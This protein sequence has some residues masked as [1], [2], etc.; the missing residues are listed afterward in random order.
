MYT[1]YHLRSANEITTD[2]IDSIKASFKSKPI[3]II[4]IV[5]ENENTFELNAETKSDLDNRL[6]KD[7]KSYLSGEEYINDS[8]WVVKSTFRLAEK[9][10]NEY[11]KKWKTETGG[12]SVTVHKV[13]NINYLQIIGMGKNA[14]PFILKDLQKGPEHWF[15]AL[16]VITKDNPV[17][18]EDMGNFGKM[19]KAWVTWGREKNII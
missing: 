2:L 10:F 7:E 5:E 13:Y 1:T 17:P 4:I 12:H 6:Q 3:T 19:A 14:L 18:R 9:Q 16:Q 15:T 11:A 8:Q